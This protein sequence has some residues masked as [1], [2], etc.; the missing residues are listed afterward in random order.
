[1]SIYGRN[2]F[3]P[4]PPKEP[5]PECDGYTCPLDQKF[6]P[7]RDA[8]CS[9]STCQR[10]FAVRMFFPV[11]VAFADGGIFDDGRLVPVFV[12]PGHGRL[13]EEAVE[14]NLPIRGS[15]EGWIWVDNT[16]YLRFGAL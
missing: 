2:P 1:M 8:S 13:L 5:E 11:K 14:K 6:G 7:Q 12:C 16:D 10:A 4:T 9:F 15:A 3:D